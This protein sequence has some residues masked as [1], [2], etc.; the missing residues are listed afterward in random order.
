MKIYGFRRP[1]GKIGIRNRVIIM[2]T[3]MC[4]SGTAQ[5]IAREVDGTVFIDN[6]Q[7]CGQTKKDVKMTIDVLVGLAANPN[8]YGT[9]LIGNGCETAEP[10]MVKKII[11][12][13]T[14][15]PLELIVIQEVDG[16]TP[17]VVQQGA[18]HARRMV[19]DALAQQ[20]V[21]FDMSEMIV[22]TECGGSDTTS[23]LAAN[24]AVGVMSD[25]I[26]GLGGT[27]M[28]SETSEMVGT[29]HILGAQSATPE[30]AAQIVKMIKDFEETIML[31]GTDLHQNNPN[32]GNHAGGLSTLEEKSL[33]CILKA[34]TTPIVEVLA[35]AQPPTKKGLVLQ[36]TPAHDM[37]SL[38]SMAAGGAQ[39][40]FFTTGRGTPTGNGIMP[41]VKLTGN[42][43]TYKRME[44]NLDIDT[45]PVIRGEKTME[46]M[47]QEIFDMLIEYING[48]PTKPESFGFNEFGIS[49]CSSYC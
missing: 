23:A 33:G 5:M 1:D 16:G 38:V 31:G 4:A 22:A 40:V 14:N 25:M 2:P 41:V 44:P 24:P 17:A 10:H 39:I 49:T 13:R 6:Q 3:S 20:R 21:E 35:Y 29:E 46:Q 15:K 12:E 32:Q 47:G 27:V 19:R 42:A 9:I 7:G 43:A 26:I 45:S 34:G 30:I 48:R 8:V 18:E 28:M 37:A 11:E 36:D